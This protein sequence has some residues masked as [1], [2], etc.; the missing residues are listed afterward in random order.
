[1][2]VNM[3]EKQLGEG[4]RNFVWNIVEI[5]SCLDA[6]HKTWAELLG[7]SEPQWLILTAIDELDK[8][9]G[10]SGVDVSTRLRVHPAFVTTQT[11]S[12]EKSGLLTRMPSST[13]ARFVLMSL[14]PLARTEIA[15]LSG[16]RDTL[17]ASMFSTLGAGALKDLNAKLDVIRKN[18]E[19]AV[20]RLAADV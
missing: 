14:T 13:D 7:I 15:K 17:N 6:I 12:L 8:G 2:E 10:V 16:K 5:H 20:R 3:S 1:M 4:I 18:A 9:D 11:K 19:R